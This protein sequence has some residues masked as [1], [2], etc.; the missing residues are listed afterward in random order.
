[1]NNNQFDFEPSSNRVQFDELPLVLK[2]MQQFYPEGD[3]ISKPSKHEYHELTYVRSGKLD[4]IIKGKRFH[5][6][7]GSTIVVRP[8]ISH[9]F[10][11]LEQC[12]IACI[13]FAIKPESSGNSKAPSVDLDPYMDFLHFANSQADADEGS[14]TYQDAMLIRGKGRRE[15]AA[16]VEQIIEENDSNDY[17]K[18]LMLQ[19]LGLQ[20]LVE[21]SRA[22]KA[23]WEES[24]KVKTGK[25]KELVHIAK[26][27]IEANYDQNIAV[28]DVAGHVFL[29]QGY[30]ARAFRDEMGLSP[31][32]YLMQVR[33]KK[34]CDLLEN[35]DMKVSTVARSVGFSS[36]Q[37]FNAAFRKQMNN[38]PMA[39]RKNRTGIDQLDEEDQD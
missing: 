19:A 4:Y 37:R 35:S 17:G 11:V 9:S 2:G 7:P 1:M 28:A 15:I 20:L 34:A 39:F 10:V 38:T 29:S 21:F 6:I 14:D 8:D 23:E 32:S 24:L 16:I 30:F 13:Y 5:L 36:P 27:Y 3:S 26:E 22:L 25:A 12:D 31:M 33:V 18:V